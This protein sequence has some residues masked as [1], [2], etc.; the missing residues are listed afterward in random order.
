M[1]YHLKRVRL[2]NVRGIK[3]A[4]ID[5]EP[6]GTRRDWTL[7]VGNNGHGKTTVLR[8]I[9]IGLADDT[10]ASEL[11]GNLPGDFI[12][13]NKQGRS[14]GSATITVELRSTRKG[15]PVS[16][17]VTT[18][19]R[20]DFGRERVAKK[21]YSADFDPSH[22]FVCAYG[23]NRGGP[24]R[25]AAEYGLRRSLMT[26]F[27]DKEA[28]L[29]PGQVLRDYMLFAHQ[30]GSPGKGPYNFVIRSL[31]KV[32][33]LPAS[34]PI[35]VTATGD[36]TVSGPWGR[37]P[38]NVLGDGYR[39]T[40]TWVLDLLGNALKAGRWKTNRTKPM[41][42]IVLVDELEE[43]LHPAWQRT[44][45]SKLRAAF[46]EVQFVATTHSPLA[47]ANTRSGEVFAAVLRNAVS[48]LEP[49]PDATGRDAQELLLGEW[50]GLDSTLDD[51]STRKLQELRAAFAAG[52]DVEAKRLR[53][54]LQRTVRSFVATPLDAVVQREV[55]R[56]ADGLH[57][58]PGGERVKAAVARAIAK[59]GKSK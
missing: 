54:E 44:I 3:D 7:L 37:L 20:D 30:R 53:S 56:A 14:E 47:L 45:V 46:P 19:A 18:I 11:L 51:A 41:R 13:R 50:F 27:S 25:D 59:L 33:D 6:E 35:V 26:L 58:P 4:T 1:A 10:T 48:T 21:T 32:W 2:Q 12:R 40:G 52:R 43:H 49:L 16:S 28:L 22:L 34:Y 17:L 29:S 39:G 15:R 36:V 9:A 8:S 42:G 23:P 57:A 31:R 38:F 55:T 5:F 24:G